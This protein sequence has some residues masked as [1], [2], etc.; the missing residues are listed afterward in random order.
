MHLKPVSSRPRLS[1]P[2]LTDL[3]VF[4]FRKRYENACINGVKRRRVAA[5]HAHRQSIVLDRAT[6]MVG[7]E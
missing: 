5:I 6:E 1:L 2:P 7:D 4:R 3:S